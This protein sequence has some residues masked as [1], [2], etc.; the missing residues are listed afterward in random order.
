MNRITAPAAAFLALGLLVT[1]CGDDGEAGSSS[2]TTTAPSDAT[3]SD[4]TVSDNSTSDDTGSDSP[5]SDDA[6]SDDAGSDDADATATTVPDPAD[7]AETVPTISAPDPDV[8]IPSV[9]LP[10]DVGLA[11]EDERGE[12]EA[13]VPINLDE[14]ASLA[15]ANAEFARDAVTADDL[16]AAIRF[17][18]ASADR[19][20]PSAVEAIAEHAGS[21]RAATTLDEVNAAVTAVLDTCVELGHQI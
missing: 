9:T 7:D 17:L 2:T 12:N 14:T 1:S 16:D 10:A 3:D 21:M 11:P 19:A 4:N 15:C 5:H 20:E 8:V 13:G 18:E 6:A